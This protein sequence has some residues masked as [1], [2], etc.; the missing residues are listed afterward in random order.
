MPGGSADQRFRGL[1]DQLV[2]GFADRA[3][4]IEVMIMGW[5]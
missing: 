3:R 2:H 4:S 1:A 5:R